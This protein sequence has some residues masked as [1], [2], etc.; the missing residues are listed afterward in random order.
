MRWE[1]LEIEEQKLGND[2]DIGRST[3]SRL[4]LRKANRDIGIKRKMDKI[5]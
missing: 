5:K 4:N 3:R 1:N 2:D